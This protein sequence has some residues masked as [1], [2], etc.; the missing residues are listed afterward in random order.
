M[1][2]ADRTPKPA[3][4]SQ[5]GK[6]YSLDAKTGARIGLPTNTRP[7]KTVGCATDRFAPGKTNSH[8]VWPLSASRKQRCVGATPH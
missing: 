5:N 8:S 2:T 7:P 4:N 6:P 3:P 1:T